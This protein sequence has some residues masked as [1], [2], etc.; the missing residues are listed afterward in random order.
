[1]DWSDR[2]GSRIKL[3]DLH[4]LMAISDA[5]SMAKAAAK[6]RISHPAIS[7]TIS[8]IEGTLGIRLL[9]RGSQGAELT[10]YGEVLLRCG[11]N[12]L[13]KCGKGFDR[14]NIWLIQTRAKDAP[15]L[16]YKPWRR[17]SCGDFHRNIPAF[18]LT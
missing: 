5:G 6:L 17:P 11:I 7:K 18:S 13:T 10:A 12:I 8:D 3:R 4:I 2:I 1:M 14:S 15:K 9:D 16:S